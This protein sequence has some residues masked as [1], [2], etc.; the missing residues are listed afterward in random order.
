MVHKELVNYVKE[1]MNQGASLIKIKEDL[2]DRGFSAEDFSNALKLAN[3]RGSSFSFHKVNFKNFLLGFFIFFIVI[4]LVVMMVINSQNNAEVYS[5]DVLKEGVNIEMKGALMEFEYSEGKTEQAR[6]VSAN[7]LI[8]EVNFGDQHVKI[9]M[10]G[11]KSLDLDSDGFFDLIVT[12]ESIK[13]SV[14]TF[15]IKLSDE[16]VDNSSRKKDKVDELKSKYDVEEVDGADINDSE[17]EVC[18]PDWDCDVWEECLS[19]QQERACVDL[20]DCETLDDIPETIRSCEDEESSEESSSEDSSEECVEEWNCTYSECINGKITEI[21]VE[22]GCGSGSNSKTINCEYNE[23]TALSI[24]EMTEEEFC[25]SKSPSDDN[26][27]HFGSN[28]TY[29]CQEPKNFTYYNVSCCANETLLEKFNATAYVS[30]SES[31]CGTGYTQD[32]GTTNL[33]IIDKFPYYMSMRDA[34]VYDTMF[35]RDCSMVSFENAL[36]DN[37]SAAKLTFN[38]SNSSGNDHI[39]SLE[40]LG[41]LPDGNCSVNFT[42]ENYKV[43]D[44]LNF[45]VNGTSMN[46][47]LPIITEGWI[48]MWTCPLGFCAAPNMPGSSIYTMLNFFEFNVE[49]G[50]IETYMCNGNMTNI[51][52]K[53]EFGFF[54]EY[55]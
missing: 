12:Y 25:V 19:G 42:I 7:S 52:G 28:D 29:F 37:C 15:S 38:V 26:Y 6:L 8:A 24:G 3:K 41:R 20:N 5:S 14:P 33:S 51:T 21:C 11:N 53:V 22:T 45:T 13:G 2:L 16:R 44:S 35:G 10:G 27:F 30:Q 31:L 47:Q 46:C 1:G 9:S 34:V 40:M 49:S 17:N 4:A 54:P 50:D 18:V 48:S 23:T 39:V 55:M 32:C 36:R 43:N